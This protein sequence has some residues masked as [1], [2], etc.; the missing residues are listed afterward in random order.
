MSMEVRKPACG[1]F[2]SSSVGESATVCA[3]TADDIGFVRLWNV[4]DREAY[5]LLQECGPFDKI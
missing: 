5:Q 3:I 4:A 2:R 1:F